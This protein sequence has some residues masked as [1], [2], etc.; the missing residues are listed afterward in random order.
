M[1]KQNVVGCWTRYAGM[2]SLES[3]PAHGSMRLMTRRLRAALAGISSLLAPANLPAAPAPVPPFEFPPS[4]EMS[5]FAKEPEVVDPVALAFDAMGRAYVVE[6]RD[7]PYGF[8]PDRRPGGTIRLLEDTDG[9]GRADRARLFAENLSY[10]TSVAPWNGGILVAAPPEILFLKDADG[11]G[12]AEIREVIL[13]GFR[14]GVTDSNLNGLRWGLDGWVHAGNGGNGG[15]VR[16]PRRPDAPAVELRDRDFRFR[17]DTG[18]V[19][20]TTHTGG[21]FGLVF[22]DWGRS[23]TTYNI[24]HIQQRVANAD[25]FSRVPGMVAVETTHSISDH[26][27]MARI[28]PVSVAQTRPNHPEQAGHFSAAGGLGFINDL[29]WPPSLLQSVLVCDVVGNLVH[30]DVLVPDGPIFRA[31]RA[32]EERDREF[33]AGRDPAFR[34]VGLEWGPDGALYLMDMQREVIEHPDY[35]PKKLL[36]KL[37]L[38]AGE[39]RGRL[40]RLVPRGWKGHRELPG[41]SPTAGLPAFLASP[42]PWTRITAQRLLLERRDPSVLPELVAMVTEHPSPHARLHALAVLDAWGTLE[43]SVLAKALKDPAPGIRENAV[44]RVGRRAASSEAWTA[45]LITATADSD[46]AVRFQAALALGTAP[47]E[48]AFHQALQT[49]LQRDFRHAWS[50]R[51][52]LSALTTRQDAVLE[53]LLRDREFM[54]SPEEARQ[55]TIEELAALVGARHRTNAGRGWEGILDGAAD[56]SLPEAVRIALLRGLN[57][58]LERSPETPSLTE[59]ARKALIHGMASSSPRMMASTWRLARRLGMSDPPETT[60]LIERAGREVLDTSQPLARRLEWLEL[61]AAG[62]FKQTRQT[63]ITLLDGRHP[64]VLQQAS[65][66]VLRSHREPEMAMGLIESWP[67]LAPGLRSEVV[68]VLVYRRPFQAALLDALE[69]GKLQV[70]ELNLDLEHRRELL[71]KAA[72]AIRE[73]AARFMSDEEYSNRKAVVDQWLETLPPTGDRGRGQEIFVRLCSPCH[74]SGDLGYEVGPNLTRMAHR[75]VEDLLSNILDPNM[76]LNP[77]FTAYTAELA[78]DEEETGILASETVDAVTLLQAQGRRIELP[79]S[80]IRR[81]RSGG[82]S[83]MPEGLE[84]GLTPQA[85]RDVI[86]FVQEGAP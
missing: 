1:D 74:R 31:T 62:D 59:G 58:G 15:R 61:L 86:A 17:P 22:D 41:E 85:M 68:Q 16:S 53:G 64:A 79:R 66:N 12:R 57:A 54:E 76:A 75:S 34:P 7:Y 63:L 8:G 67:T 77:T 56:G 2:A 36:E 69:S 82:R 32:D 4:L 21:G 42:N 19:E 27:D 48:A 46:I 30:R 25:L 6:M 29:R 73:R 84:S 26:G 14:L 51:A 38:R 70:G 49:L 65:F 80:R 35:I 24:N 72:P 43:D 83:L 52:V 5:L 18:E 20:L 37:D 81:L 39:D 60:G 28:F 10:P 3:S 23:F 33:L 13:T 40:Y 45:A 44:A 55:E 9:D 78:D 11:D 50:R 71:R 47:N